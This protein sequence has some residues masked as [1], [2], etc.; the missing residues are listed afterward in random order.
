MKILIIGAGLVGLTNAYILAKNGH[1][2]RI[3]ER[4]S[5]VGEE[6]SFSNGGQ[7]SYC[8][9]EPWASYSSL[10]KAVKWIGK[11]DAPLLFR[12]LP[13]IN[14]WK[15]L[16][17]FIMQASNKANDRNTRKILELGLYS[18]HVLH[19][20]EEDLEFDFSY[21]KGGKI[22]F[23]K[24]KECMDTYL[25]Q[26]RKQELLGSEYQILSPQETLEYE[27]SLN[28]HIADIYGCIRDPLDES[29]DAYKFC[30]GMSKQLEK[31][32]VKIEYNTNFEEFITKGDKIEAIKTDR[33]D[34]TADKFILS[35]GVYS[36]IMAR[37]IG[38]NLPIY[39]IK[40]YSITVDIE[41]G[42]NA[43]LNSI[44]DHHEKIVYSKLGNKLRA[45][46]TAEFAGYDTSIT[47][48][49][50]DMM[51]NSAKRIFPHLKNI[52]SA[53]SW[54]CLRPSTPDGSPILG[55]TDKYKNLILNTGHGTLGWTQTFASAQIVSDF[56]EGKETELNIDEYSLKR[57]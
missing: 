49:R 1:E 53:S 32:G 26:A 48:K 36:P 9:A 13:D 17:K 31:M 47:E 29:A 25:I 30:T 45:A 38:I 16:S 19:N 37:K 55:G 10:I 42:E 54:A 43:P 23:F 24:D 33:G 28:N 27:P 56:I 14:M 8:H 2:V 52:D 35:T 41:E 18:R 12:P 7:L 15:W 11:S 20:I 21:E 6:C 22:F 5:G 4:N 46:G 34:F 39:P 44:T 57:F 50:I 40:G 3:I 51:K